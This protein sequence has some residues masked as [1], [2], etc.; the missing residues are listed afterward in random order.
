MRDIMIA[1]LTGAKLHIQHISTAKGLDMVRAAKAKGLPVTCEATP[2]HLFLTE[3]AIDGT[4]NTCFKVNPPLRTAAD[5]EALIAGVI[6]G[7]VDAIATDHAPH[8]DWEKSREFELAPFGMTG[9]ETALGLV[10]TNLVKTGKITFARMVE[11]MAIEPRKILGLDQVTIAEG[12]VAD[13]TVFDADVAWTV[14]E[15]DFVSHAKNSGFKG[16][17]RMFSWVESARSPTA[18]FAKI[19]V[20][21]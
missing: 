12:S 20:S 5:A 16:A 3:D 15:D 17:P 4:Y 9:L 18:S 1:E 11:L 7:T 21:A 13:L 10:I 14:S 6:D 8:S 2:H 19:A